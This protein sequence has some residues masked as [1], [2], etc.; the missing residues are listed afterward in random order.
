[1]LIDCRDRLRA[2][3]FDDHRSRMEQLLSRHYGRAGWHIS[4]ALAEP[5]ATAAMKRYFAGDLAAL[6]S[7]T[8]HCGGTGFQRSVWA[9][10]RTIESGTTRSYSAVAQ[11]IGHPAAT[12]AVGAA[13]GANPIAIVVPCHRVIGADG[14]L[15]GFGGGIERKRWLLDHET[16]HSRN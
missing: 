15:T 16:N 12:R 4:E 5:S 9:A 11:Q 13:N 6:G 1:M 10:L 2:L 14:S 7:I 8:T 3:D